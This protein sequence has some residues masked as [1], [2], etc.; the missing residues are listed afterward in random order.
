MNERDKLRGRLAVDI[1]LVSFAVPIAIV[2]VFELRQIMREIE[3]AIR[4]DFG[5]D[6]ILRARRP[7]FILMGL[8]ALVVLAGLVS[9][10]RIVVLSRRL[11]RLRGNPLADASAERAVTG[12][13]T[14]QDKYLAQLEEYLRNGI[15]D[16]AEY[17]L[18]KERYRKNGR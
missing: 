10:V 12:A 16:R 13:R 15:I 8:G 9:L 17:R 14:G 11:N 4:V 18:L 2:I 6:R 7:E 1:L 3:W 5:V